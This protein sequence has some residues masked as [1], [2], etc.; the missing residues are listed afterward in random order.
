MLD[1]ANRNT[2]ILDKLA[3]TDCLLQNWYH[4]T[5]SVTYM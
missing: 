3:H 2:D 4:I 5:F 1:D